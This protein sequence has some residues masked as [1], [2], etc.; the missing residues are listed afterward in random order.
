[1][2]IK[3]LFAVLKL[4][5]QKVLESKTFQTTLKK[6]RTIKKRVLYKWEI[7]VKIKQSYGH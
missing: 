7:Q 1:M 4:L 3:C 5:S 2:E 6:V